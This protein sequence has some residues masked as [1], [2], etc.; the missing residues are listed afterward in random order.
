MDRATHIYIDAQLGDEIRGEDVAKEAHTLG[1]RTI[2]L[3]TGLPVDALEPC[4]W[5]LGVLGKDPPWK[6]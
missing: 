2:F 6:A 4:P 3:C 1:F 5:V